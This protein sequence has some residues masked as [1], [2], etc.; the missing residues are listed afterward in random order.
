[1]CVI[2]LKTKL[3]KNQRNACL[4][5]CGLSFDCSGWNLGEDD[6]K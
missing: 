2:F 6:P 3:T 5:F 4:M 1:M